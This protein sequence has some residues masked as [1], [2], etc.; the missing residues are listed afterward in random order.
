VL[1][2]YYKG[3]T[4]VFLDVLCEFAHDFEWCHFVMCDTVQVLCNAV[5]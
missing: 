2:G 4:K 3:V 1:Q 5:R